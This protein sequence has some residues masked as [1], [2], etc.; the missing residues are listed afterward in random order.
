MKPA[1]KY[2]LPFQAKFRSRGGKNNKA[3]RGRSAPSIGVHVTNEVNKAN[4][5]KNEKVSNLIITNPP[6]KETG[7]YSECELATQ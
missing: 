3:D 6:T 2:R 1:I 7:T 5:I 4:K